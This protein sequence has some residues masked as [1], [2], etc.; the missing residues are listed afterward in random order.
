MHE[1]PELRDFEDCLRGF[2]HVRL[3]DHSYYPLEL[4]E[5]RELPK[6]AAPGLHRTPFQLKF[7]GPGPGYLPQ[8]IHLLQNDKLG[9]HPL[10]LV[11]I[12][13]DQT[14]FVYQAVF[15]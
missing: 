7:R 3:V 5:A 10:F 15:N 1:L 14:G 11:P 8:Q 4:I 2:F 13:Q 9:T 12:G 6:S